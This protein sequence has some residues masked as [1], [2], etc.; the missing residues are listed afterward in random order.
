MNFTFKSNTKALQAV[1]RELR[2]SKMRMLDVQEEL[3]ATV[4]KSFDSRKSPEGK[5]WKAKSKNTLEIEQRKKNKG[6]KLQDSFL[7]KRETN[8][9][10]YKTSSPYARAQQFGNPLQKAFGRGNAPLPA[11][12]YLPIDSS[13]K[14]MKDFVEQL[15]KKLVEGIKKRTGMVK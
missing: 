9:L 7:G 15:Q 8:G 11:R 12:P 3:N 6:Q 1:I 14:V 4:K 5:D 10:L 2:D 13:Q